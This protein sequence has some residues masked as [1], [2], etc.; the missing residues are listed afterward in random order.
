MSYKQD[1]SSEKSKQFGT[2]AN[3]NPKPKQH[4]L[5][6]NGNYDFR[7]MLNMSH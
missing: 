2:I 5:N 3:A 6:T 1:S 7:Q 4:T